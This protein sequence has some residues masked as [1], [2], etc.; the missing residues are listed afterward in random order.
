MTQPAT[1]SKFIFSEYLVKASLVHD[2]ASYLPA[3]IIKH[4]CANK[5]D[6]SAGVYPTPVP[7]AN[8]R[9]TWVTLSY[10]PKVPVRNNL[11]IEVKVTFMGSFISS[12]P[13]I[14]DAGPFVVARWVREY[15]RDFNHRTSAEVTWNRILDS[16]ELTVKKL[17]MAMPPPL[18]L[19]PQNQEALDVFDLLAEIYENDED[20]EDEE[21]ALQDASEH[22]RMVVIMEAEKAAKHTNTAPPHPF[23]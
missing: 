2:V 12:A 17:L 15:L 7:G 19:H 21:E 18:S 20:D 23:P 9:P 22:W 16:D 8:G 13:E 10:T 1:T 14:L 3:V 5:R 6:I 11:E 4:L